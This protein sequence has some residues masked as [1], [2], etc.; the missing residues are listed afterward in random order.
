MDYQKIWNENEEIRK[1]YCEGRNIPL[2]EQKD[3]PIDFEEW[4]RW[5]AIFRVFQDDPLGE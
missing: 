2:E 5:E 4:L 1:A 3:L